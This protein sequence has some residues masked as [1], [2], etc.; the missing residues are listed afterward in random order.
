MGL[1]FRSTRMLA[2]LIALLAV[3]L[4]LPAATVYYEAAGDSC[5]RCHEIRESRDAW[6]VSTHR[7]VK[8]QQCHGGV[9]TADLGFHL[10]NAHRVLAH[11]RGKVPGRVRIKNDDAL[12]LVEQCRSCH[13]QQYADWQASRHSA[14]YQRIFLDKDHNRKEL[15]IDDCLRC[16]GMYYE[17]SIRDLV[18]P[19]ST[20]GPW[21]LSDARL[22][23][24]P[25]IPCTACHQ[26]HRQGDPAVKP[27]P[28]AVPI[29]ANEPVSRPSLGAFNR[30]E[31]MHGSVRIL[32]MPHMRDGRRVV[33]LSPDPRQGLCYQCHA[34]EPTFQVRTGDDRTPIGV[35]EGIG[36]LACHA[37]HGRKTRA[38]CATCHP[39]LSNCGQDVEKMDTTFKLPKSPHNIHFVK[40]LDCHPKGI[41]RK[42]K[43]DGTG[44]TAR[45]SAE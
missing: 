2:A 30:R 26:M 23:T 33:R 24:R 14:T 37:S 11:F 10:N 34:P 44:W 40:C 41:P 36:C 3:L 4:F 45:V 12:R 42:K 35:H 9:L 29:A 17:G 5:A 7:V 22:A 38:S 27:G 20:R 25:T 43:Q 16:H 19:I 21:K 6:R 18:T 39:R 13:Q 28:D 32:A 15:L 8:C 31:M 1:N